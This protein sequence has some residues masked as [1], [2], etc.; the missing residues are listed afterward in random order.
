MQQ[1]LT[2]VCVGPK[3]YFF[4]GKKASVL[5]FGHLLL[6]QQIVLNDISAKLVNQRQGSL[7]PLLLVTPKCLLDW[8]TLFQIIFS[9]F[10][11][12]FY[13]STSFIICFVN[14][15]RRV[16]TGV[17]LSS[18]ICSSVVCVLSVSMKCVKDGLI[19]CLVIAQIV[20][21]PLYPA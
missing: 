8:I 1:C 17:P 18:S 12:S 9:S 15:V 5:L 20:F 11:V 21:E 7:F 19:V 13:N 2:C 4:R 6:S 14:L 10:L 3:K 16:T